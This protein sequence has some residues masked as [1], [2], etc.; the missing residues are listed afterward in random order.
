MSLLYKEIA[1]QITNY[2]YDNE[3][4]EKLPTEREL[5][6]KYEVSRQTIRKA[7]ELCE[8]NGLIKRRQ[9][10]GIYLSS[11]Y[12]LSVN[13]VALLVPSKEEYIYPKIISELEKR[14]KSISFTLDIY[15]TLDTISDEKAI[16]DY[17]LNNP[18]STLLVIQNRNMLP[19]PLSYKYSQ[20]SKNGTNII[21]I[22][23]PCPNLSDYTYIKFDDFFSGYSIAE[24]I[25]NNEQNW[26]AIFISDNRG[27][28]DRY[29]GFI[30]YLEDNNYEYNESNIHWILYDDILDIRHNNTECLKRIISKY[31]QMPSTFICGQ[32]EIA[33][34][35]IMHLKNIRQ[36]SDDISFYS[37]DNSFLQTL[38]YT[39]VNSFDG[40]KSMLY[41]KIMECTL[42][43]HKKK[44]EV[45]TLPSKLNH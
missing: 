5:S 15:E 28:T 18:V 42:S 7:L 16:L 43:G 30:Q 12:L 25:A 8:A 2:I 4:K 19:S 35:L 17:I 21:F 44:K 41:S 22:G 20:L 13:H 23:N 14:Y 24:R 10:S 33:Y 26:C 45:F 37:F 29:Y 6:I 9:G 1:D 39:K 36:L 11:S 32:D 31:E 34:S 3:I 40:D 38:I 27:S